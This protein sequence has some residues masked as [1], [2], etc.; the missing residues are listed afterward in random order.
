MKGEKRHLVKSNVGFIL[1]EKQGS[2]L[3]REIGKI[4]HPQFVT[5]EYLPEHLCGHERIIN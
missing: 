1:I 3:L 4:E 5:Y 2:K